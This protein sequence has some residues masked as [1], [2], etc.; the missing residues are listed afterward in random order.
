MKLLARENTQPKEMHIEMPISF[1]MKGL[2]SILIRSW[3]TNRKVRLLAKWLSVKLLK[4]KKCN[5]NCS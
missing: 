5:N 1:S 3:F 2:K 4:N